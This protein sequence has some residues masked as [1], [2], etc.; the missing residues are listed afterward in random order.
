MCWVPALGQNSVTYAI[1]FIYRASLLWSEKQTPPGEA[2]SLA[3]APKVNTWQSSS[4]HAIHSKAQAG[5]LEKRNKKVT[6]VGK[7]G[8][9]AWLACEMGEEVPRF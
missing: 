6:K 9:T 5:A 7:K 2:K 4:L 1:S 8:Q 3:C